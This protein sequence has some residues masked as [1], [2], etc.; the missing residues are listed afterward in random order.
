MSRTKMGAYSVSREEKYSELEASFKKVCAKLSHRT[1]VGNR[2]AATLR[3]A[4]DSA[5]GRLG[6]SFSSDA[7]FALADWR[8]ATK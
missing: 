5:G 1:R 6:S 8:D 7:N 4:R 2:L 3:R